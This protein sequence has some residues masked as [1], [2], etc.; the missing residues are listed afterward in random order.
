MKYYNY[1]SAKIS[2]TIKGFII[3]K[4]YKSQIQK[5][6]K[7]KNLLSKFI[8]S[9]K[10]R[11]ILRTKKLQNYL[12]DIGHMKFLLVNIYS[13]TRIS[14]KSEKLKN[15]LIDKYPKAIK[16]FHMEFYKM[17]NK[18]LWVKNNIRIKQCWRKEYLNYLNFQELIKGNMYKNFLADDVFSKKLNLNENKFY[19]KTIDIHNEKNGNSYYDESDTDSDRDIDKNDNNNNN[20]NKNPFKTQDEFLKENNNYI[21]KKFSKENNNNNYNTLYE[22]YKENNSSNNLNIKI[23]NFSYNN[24]DNNIYKSNL[25][26]KTSS[27]FSLGKNI[28]NENNENNLNNENKFVKDNNNSNFDNFNNNYINSSLN[29]P[30]ENS[31]SKSNFLI[32]KSKNKNKIEIRINNLNENNNNTNYNSY[33]SFKYKFNP[34]DEKPIKSN[35]N[36]F[37]DLI[38]GKK[39]IENINIIDINKNTNKDLD[40][41]DSNKYINIDND[42]YANANSNITIDGVLKT[43]DIQ[44]TKTNINRPRVNPIRRKQPKYDARKAIMESKTKDKLELN[45]NS[46]NSNIKDINSIN[47]NINKNAN[48]INSNNNNNSIDNYKLNDDNNSKNN[49]ISNIKLDDNRIINKKKPENNINSNVSKKNININIKI[50]SN[51]KDNDK[52]KDKYKDNYNTNT[53]EDKLNIKVI[54]IDLGS[55]EE[56]NHFHFKTPSPL[57]SN[58]IKNNELD[59]YSSYNNNKKIQLEISNSNLNNSCKLL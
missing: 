3:R 24:N 22:S 53:N 4:K 28:L 51:N 32:N 10:I 55:E 9:F 40:N 45:N 12:N 34:H 38:K 26:R 6:K 37:N 59:L 5:I 41:I 21:S 49:E 8:N 58:K 35:P 56:K 47:I 27:S 33:S 16:N 2:K 50:N 1:C 17:K 44:E 11:M 54:E 7:A 25:H 20:R 13:E 30:L 48:A 23:N 36:I 15:E 14:Q 52:D 46:D 19:K 31:Q 29:F 57:I 18:I 39:E 42:I 43:E